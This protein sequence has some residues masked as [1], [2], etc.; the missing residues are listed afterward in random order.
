[1]SLS[2][3]ALREEYGRGG[4][5]ERLARHHADVDAAFRGWCDAWLDPA[6]RKWDITEFLPRITQPVLLM[7]GVDDPYGTPAQL[8]TAERLA[9]APLRTMLI[10]GV[11]HAPHA[12]AAELVTAEIA[13]FVEGA[14][15]V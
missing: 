15:A 12:E 5:R 7:Q 6:F 2:I 4:L 14:L 8:A 11:G 13:R 3:A 9:T 1:M 10:P